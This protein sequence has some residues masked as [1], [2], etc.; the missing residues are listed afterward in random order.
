[1]MHDLYGPIVVK[2]DYEKIKKDL[3]KP[4][5]RTIHGFKQYKD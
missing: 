5:H 3:N 1:M 2:G 4:E